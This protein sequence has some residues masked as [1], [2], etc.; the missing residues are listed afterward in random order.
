L[1]GLLWLLAAPHYLFL[2]FG[3]A[4]A[5]LSPGPLWDRFYLALV[6]LAVVGL[7]HQCISLLRP[8]WIWF[9]Y[10]ARL[11]TTV[12]SMIVLNFMISAAT[13][14]Q[15]G[16]WHPFVVLAGSGP[17][18]L[19]HARIVATVNAGVLLTLA[20]VWIGLSI[21][22]VKQTWELLQELRQQPR[23]A[24]DRALLRFL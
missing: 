16:E 24:R 17:T 10:A 14:N 18:S 23:Q 6:L 5:F 4:A 15:G 3:P 19:Q 8:R 12:L 2:V 13:Q 1:V 20:C 9:P 21:A 7:V 11:L 22:G